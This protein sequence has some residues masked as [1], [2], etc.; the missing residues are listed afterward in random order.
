MAGS[1]SGNTPQPFAGLHR[2]IGGRLSSGGEQGF[3]ILGSPA[4]G[5]NPTMSYGLEQT[6][7]PSFVYTPEDKPKQLNRTTRMRLAPF[8]YDSSGRSE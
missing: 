7:Q 8:Y 3:G 6:F 1:G 5:L 2:Y 4:Y